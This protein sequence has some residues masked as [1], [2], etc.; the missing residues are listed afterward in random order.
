[1]LLRNRTLVLCALT[2]LCTDISSEMVYPLLPVFLTVTLGARPGTLGLIEGV[3]ESLAQLLRVFAGAWSDRLGRRKPLAAAG[4]AGSALGKVL[5]YVATSAG[6]VFAARVVDRF[7]KGIRS[8]PRDAMI[9][10]AVPPEIRGKA[11]GFHRAMD[12]LGAVIGIAVAYVV[13]GHAADGIR[14][15]LLISLVPATLGIAAMM[16][17]RESP[18]RSPV[19]RREPFRPREAWRALSRRLKV[20][21]VIV[22]VFTLGNSSNQFLMLRASRL[23]FDERQVVLLYLLMTVVYTLTSFPAG[24][25]SDRVGRK[26][27]LVAGFAVHGLVYLGFALVRGA[28]DGLGAAAMAGLFGVYGLHV[29]L[30]DGVEK[31]LLTDLAPADLKASVLGLNATIIGLG[32]L[33]ASAVAGALWDVAG[34]AAPFYLGAALG[35]AA[36]A[37]LWR[38]L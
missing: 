30:T 36:A 35:L 5:L 6:W 15:V 22:A 24:W 19:V 27:L 21:L 11:F 13:L 28:P 8:A 23:G 32:L 12:S 16:A 4:Y 1:V 9:A 7:G 25:L 31:A 34:P 17:V 33:P 2:S 26:G 3:A 29:G 20:Y 18:A 37:A 10:E 38:M 14:A